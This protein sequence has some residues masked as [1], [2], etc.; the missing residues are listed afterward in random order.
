[1]LRVITSFVVAYPV[2]VE[3]LETIDEVLMLGLVKSI[4]HVIPAAVG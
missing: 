2:F 3:L 4:G 1:M